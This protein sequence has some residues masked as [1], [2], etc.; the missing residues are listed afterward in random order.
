VASID[1]EALARAERV[2]ELVRDEWL[3]R[4]GVTAV[5]MGFKWSGGEMTDVVSLRVHVARKR[6]AADLSVAELFPSEVDGVPIDVI[7]ASYTP[8]TLLDIRAEMAAAGRG[9][10]FKVVP[11]GVSVGCRFT[12]AGTLGA[13]VIDQDSGEEMILSNWHVLAGN[14]NAQSGLSIWQPGQLDGRPDDKS[15]IA[16]LTRWMLGPYDAA[17]A[18]LNGKRKV[19][20]KTVE[21]TSLLDATSPRLGMMVWKSGRTTGHTQ[22]IIDGI[23]MK[24]P[25][26]YPQEGTHLLEQVFRIVPRPGVGDVEISSSGDSGSVW[27]DEAS[28]KAV[29]LHFA[30]EA[31]R[32]P[33]HALAHNIDVVMEA[34]RVRLPG[35]KPLSASNEP[36]RPPKRRNW[37]RPYVKDS[38]SLF[39]QRLLRYSRSK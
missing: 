14:R 23:M 38:I 29:G 26:A 12:T 37:P 2:L 19:T 32:H 4:P 39:L 16:E 33:E 3:R 1:T 5:D 11:I 24:V 28:G 7:A 17:V 6:D 18:L 27:V 10:R 30:G 31:S 35:Q 13:K 21:G 15:A 8:Q 34:L 9:E 25:L 22:G 20:S 36:S